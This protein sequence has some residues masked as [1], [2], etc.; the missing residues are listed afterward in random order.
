MKNDFILGFNAHKDSVTSLDC[1][2]DDALIGSGSVDCT[3]KIINCQSNK[4]LST[5]KCGESVSQQDENDSVESV[6]FC[7][8]LPL[9]ATGTVNGAIE[10]WDI[11]NHT[12][13]HLVE[14]TNGVSKL[15]WSPNSNHL[16]FAAGLDGI[17]RIY[18]GR[19]G[20]LYD[21]KCGH[22]DQILDF[23]VSQERILTASEDNTCRVFSL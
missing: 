9:F 3:A 21:T 23:C 5:F 1:T 17:L 16:L 14:Q 6:D 19:S 2:K 11:T 12:R 18:D 22:S 15:S 10:I 7:S 13:R 8:S 20:Q 4:V